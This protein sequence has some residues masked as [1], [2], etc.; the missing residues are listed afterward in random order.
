MFV[1]LKKKKMQRALS[2]K[3]DVHA[4][5]WQPSVESP[6]SMLL[7]QVTTQHFS[8]AQVKTPIKAPKSTTQHACRKNM[9]PSQRPKK[10]LEMPPTN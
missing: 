5:L 1:H 7:L 9:P 8:G 4:V 3:R 2:G 10:R 6:F